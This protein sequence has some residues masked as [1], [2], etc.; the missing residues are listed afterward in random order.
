[1]PTLFE[2]MQQNMSAAPEAGAN[3]SQEDIQA[4]LRAK[5]GRARG[6]AG[7]AASGLAAESAGA[8]ADSA[9][10]QGQM[11]GT[12][13]ASQMAGA[14]DAQR[15]QVAGAENALAAQGRMG[16]SAL[17]ARGIGAREGLAGQQDI[18]RGERS[19]QET[20]KISSINAAATNQLRAIETQKGVTL[21]DLFAHYK[22]SNQELAF[23]KDA[24]E[25]EDTAFRLAMSD[26]AYLEE[27]NK[28][29]RERNL[30]DSISF[31]EE[32]NGIALGDNL[33]SAMDEIGFSEA[34]GA[35][36]REWEKALT[37]MG[38]SAKIEL[39]RAMIADDQK[40]S[41]AEGIGNA[42]TEGAKA[43]EKMPTEKP[44][45][46]AGDTDLGDATTYSSYS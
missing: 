29:A 15:A 39:A 26:K 41:I 40:R 28:V 20:A 45:T 36:Q 22:Q 25:L 8:Q 33:S 1:M 35:S 31:Q 12:L 24:A 2:Q 23:R 14:A 10:K 9:I 16:E 44:E 43:Y 6:G 17:A 34:F 46:T 38:S 19:A 3:S 21:D 11:A 37:S 5:S 4:V 42:A 13:A 18:A 32:M 27:L 7:P 30:S